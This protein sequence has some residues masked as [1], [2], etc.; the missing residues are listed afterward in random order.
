MKR[1]IEI[2]DNQI[3]RIYIIKVYVYS[4]RNWFKRIDWNLEWAQYVGYQR[5]ITIKEDFERE[6]QQTLRDYT[7]EEVHRTIITNN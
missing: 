2:I 5:R 4:K 6:I 7:F 3:I 1:K